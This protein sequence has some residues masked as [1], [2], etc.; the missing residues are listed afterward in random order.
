LESVLPFF[1][2]FYGILAASLF[3][4]I[5]LS[6]VLMAIVIGLSTVWIVAAMVRRGAYSEQV[7]WLFFNGFYILGFLLIHL[8]DRPWNP[9]VAR[10][11]NFTTAVIL[12]LVLVFLFDLVA[13]RI[14]EQR[15][16]AQ[17]ARA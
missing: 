13:T 17:S 2:G 6:A 12:G 10:I 5:Q 11:D 7:P 9:F 4:D 15:R 3:K 1:R 8:R 14:L 16:T